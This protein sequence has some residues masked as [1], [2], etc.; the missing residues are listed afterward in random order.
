M[1]TDVAN[2]ISSKQAAAAVNEWLVSYVGDRFL[3]GQPK[4]DSKTD[5]WRIPILFLYPQEGPIG[6]AGE[7]AVD[8]LTG[9]VCSRPAISEIK[10]RAMQLFEERRGVSTSSISAA[11]N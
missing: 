2:I 9:E 6:E 8:A 11:R 3:A 4:L 10:R 5:V 7:A 1:I